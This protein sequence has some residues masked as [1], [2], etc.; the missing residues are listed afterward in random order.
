MRSRLRPPWIPTSA[1]CFRIAPYSFFLILLLLTVD[2]TNE[3]LSR[4]PARAL[5][6]SIDFLVSVKA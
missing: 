6:V 1:L 3:L 5:A 2:A 4:L